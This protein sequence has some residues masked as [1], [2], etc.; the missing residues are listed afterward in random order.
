M[1]CKNI[2]LFSIDI[3]CGTDEAFTCLKGIRPGIPDAKGI[4]YWE[5]LEKGDTVFVCTAMS[6][7]VAGKIMIRIVQF[8][9]D[10]RNI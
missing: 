10:V 9:S 1:S 3:N 7:V 2:D 4:G 6:Y 5:T 8:F